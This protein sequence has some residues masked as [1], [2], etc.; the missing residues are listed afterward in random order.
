MR[1]TVPAGFAIETKTFPLSEVESVWA[2]SE[3]TPR[4][5]FQMP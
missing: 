4:I 1:A 3:N 5:V 2:A